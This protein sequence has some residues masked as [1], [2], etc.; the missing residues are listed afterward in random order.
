MRRLILILVLLFI[1]VVLHAQADNPTDVAHGSEKAGHEAAHPNEEHGGH[2]EEPKFAG[3]PAWIWKLANMLIFIGALAFFLGGPIKRSLA[4]RH[5]AI[6]AAAEEAKARR[7][8]ADQIAGDIQAR[9]AQLEDEIKQIHERAQ[10]EGERQRR[11]LIAAAE[12]EAQKI[13]AQA[14]NEVDNRLKNARH[15]LTEYAG[16]LASERA[17]QIL[18]ERITPEDQK[19]LF[20]ASLREVEEVRS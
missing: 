7:Q 19:K 12:A 18:R 3:L 4:D 13:L 16:Q 20:D 15:E 9:L 2:T 17:E 8:K 10:Q 6:Q 11:E 14:R 5:T 1:P